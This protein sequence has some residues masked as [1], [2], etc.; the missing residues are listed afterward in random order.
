MSATDRE[1]L[2]RNIIAGLPGSEEH[3]SIRQFQE[4]LATYEGISREQLQMH[5]IEFL[6]EVVP[7]AEACG[8]KMAIHPDDPPYAIFGLP[9]RGE[10]RSGCGKTGRGC[11]LAEQWIVLLYGLVWGDS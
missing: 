6:K 4:A 3:F 2:Q 5:L 10:Y 9:P 7:V 11:A 8:I 1:T